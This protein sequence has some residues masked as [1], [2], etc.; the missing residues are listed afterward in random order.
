M[1][2]WKVSFPL[3]G[4]NEHNH[5][6]KKIVENEVY[7]LNLSRGCGTLPSHLANIQ[8]N[9]RA[10]NS[11]TEILIIKIHK[12]YKV[13]YIGLKIN[14]LLIQPQCH[15]SKRLY[16]ESKPC[17]Y[18]RTSPSRQFITNSNQPSRRVAQVRN[19]D[20]INHLPLMIFIWLH[21]QESHLHN[22]CWFCSIKS[23]FMSKLVK[24][25]RRIH[26]NSTGKVR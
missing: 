1:W 24:T 25:C 7:Q 9:Y 23:L 11:K 3:A 6:L 2:P 22:K 19:R 15:I 13:L 14:F 21:S 17:V 4:L 12:T 20:Q 5:W 8:W 10:P 26:P 18:L 16:G